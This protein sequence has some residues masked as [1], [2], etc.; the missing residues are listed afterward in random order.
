MLT[1]EGRAVIVDFGLVLDP[2]RTRITKDGAFVGTFMC[3]SPEVLHLEA[4]IPATD[5][6]AWGLNLYVLCEGRF[7]FLF[8]QLMKVT[9]HHPLPEVR[10]HR[11]RKEGRIARVIQACLQED[12]KK[13]P[14]SKAEISALLRSDGAAEPIGPLEA[15]PLPAPPSIEEISKTLNSLEITRPGNR[16]G[17]ASRSPSTNTPTDPR[18]RAGAAA[19][20]GLVVLA[21]AVALRSSGG[22]APLDPDAPTPLPP[23]LTERMTKEFEARAPASLDP[24][25]VAWG[26]LVSTLPALEAWLAWLGDGGRPDT[27]TVEQQLALR[28]VG[29][30]YAAAGLWD[31]THPFL[32]AA[33]LSS[34]VP[35]PEE[36]RAPA[37][38]SLE[39]PEQVTGWAGA[40]LVAL[41]EAMREHRRLF[42]VLLDQQAPPPEGL[43]PE[44]WGERRGLSDGGLI[45][46]VRGGLADRTPEVERARRAALARW[47]RSGARAYTLALYAGAR[48]AATEGEVGEVVVLLLAK[49]GGRVTPFYY[50]AYRYT[51]MDSLL[52]GPARTPAHWFLRGTSLELT[53]QVRGRHS[54]RGL[55]GLRQAA[56]EALGKALD[57][58]T[59]TGARRRR[60]AALTSA[61]RAAQLAGDGMMLGTLWR[62]NG[63][64]RR[65]ADPLSHLTILRVTAETLLDGEVPVAL[66]EAERTELKGELE[67]LL[68]KARP[69]TAQAER[70]LLGRL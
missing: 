13:R 63:E 26:G 54:D 11:L 6:Y 40:S 19:G 45:H 5:W 48:S 44:L 37:F 65:T 10:F 53:A 14:T 16:S 9:E 36:L 4:A 2:N 3:A 70:A 17:P 68:A 8:P 55:R 15:R 50:D 66:S 20:L 41:D 23:G 59:G 22:P 51:S 52:A 46:F 32:V 69:G 67:G 24:D 34:P 25:P 49:L 31:P 56:R 42:Q 62:Q 21:A 1:N 29:E 38:A 7:P 60:V 57:P 47:L 35:L 61:T 30:A 18:R 43:S 64:L 27:L 28:Q 33:P 39:L 12:P 58:G